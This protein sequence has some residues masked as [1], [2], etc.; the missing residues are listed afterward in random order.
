[1]LVDIIFFLFGYIKQLNQNQNEA[2]L[3]V[4]GINTGITHGQFKVALQTLQQK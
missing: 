1:M 4:I 3:L 2:A